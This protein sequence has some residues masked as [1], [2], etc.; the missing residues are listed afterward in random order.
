MP[1][2]VLLH[3]PKANRLNDLLVVTRDPGNNK[4]EHVVNF[5]RTTNLVAKAT[6]FPL[7]DSELTY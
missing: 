1:Q 3:L 7:D 5:V 6:E 2:N 4:Q